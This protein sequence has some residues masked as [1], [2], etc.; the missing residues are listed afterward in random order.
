M[1]AEVGSDDPDP[2]TIG[3]LV[4]AIR[5]LKARICA[6]LREFDEDFEAILDEDQLEKWL[7]IK[8]RFCTARDRCRPHRDRPDDGDANDEG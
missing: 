3:D 4:L 6:T 8:H 1:K 7:T 2:C 5:D